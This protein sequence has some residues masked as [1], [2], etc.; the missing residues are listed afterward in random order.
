MGILGDFRRS[1]WTR[2]SQV[3]FSAFTETDIASAFE[4]SL[5]EIEGRKLASPLYPIV[6]RVPSEVPF[7]Y[8]TNYVAYFNRFIPRRLWPDKPR[9]I[10]LEC[11]EVFYGRSNSG[12]VPPGRL[13]EAYWSGGFVGVAIVFFV[14]GH[15]LKSFGNFFVR[16]RG[17]TIATLLLFGHDYSVR[18]Q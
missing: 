8:G 14:W 5:N 18:P 11:A 15:L 13:G 16:F 17:S 1:N 7:K 3:N 2:G 12:G 4:S 6:A 10:G 9:G